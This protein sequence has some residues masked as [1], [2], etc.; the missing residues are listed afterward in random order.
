MPIYEFYCPDNHK[1]YCFFAK[2]IAIGQQIPKCPDNPK[3]RM[4]KQVSQVSM[5][6]GAKSENEQSGSDQ[7]TVDDTRLE[8]AMAELE[9]D[10][11]GMDEETPDPRQMGR[12]MRKMADLIGEK[13]EPGMEEMIGRLEGGEDPEKL[14]DQFGDMMDEPDEGDPNGAEPAS[15]ASRSTSRRRAP[16]RDPHLYDMEDYA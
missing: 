11:S 16:T 15:T 9:R 14:E 8:A 10:V 5:L 1:I 7:D 4:V 6:A 13:M 12:L 3:Y 2:S